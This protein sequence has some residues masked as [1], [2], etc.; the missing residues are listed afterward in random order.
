MTRMSW[1]EGVI[2]GFEYIMKLRFL[3][4]IGV[5]PYVNPQPMDSKSR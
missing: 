4:I 5:R 1:I 3:F 2:P